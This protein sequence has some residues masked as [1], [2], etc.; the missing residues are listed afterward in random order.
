MTDNATLRESFKKGANLSD[1]LKEGDLGDTAFFYQEPLAEEQTKVLTL[2]AEYCRR[3]HGRIKS[4]GEYKVEIDWKDDAG[5][6]IYT[7]TI[8]DTEIGGTWT[9]Y[10][11]VVDSPHVDIKISHED[12]ENGEQIVD[13]SFVLS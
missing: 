8:V 11:E 13:A 5:N 2:D 6:V 10:N 3:L 1:L 7:E 4:D 12:A 9:E